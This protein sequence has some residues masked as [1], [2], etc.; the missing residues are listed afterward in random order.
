[1][2]LDSTAMTLEEVLAAAEEVVRSH[3]EAG[4]L[5]AKLH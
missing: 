3:V 1:V 4:K 5:Q 2:I